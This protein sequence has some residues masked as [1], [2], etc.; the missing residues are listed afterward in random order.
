VPALLETSRKER[1]S[2]DAWLRQAQYEQL[3]TAYHLGERF[4]R[5][6]DEVFATVQMVVQILRR[7]LLNAASQSAE[8]T[9]EDAPK[10]LTARELSQA[11]AATLRCLGDLGVNARPRLTLETMVMSWP[12]MSHR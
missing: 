6:R 2:A 8:A 1:D 5:N 11:I 7:E 3:I 9:A 10:T 12:D 4:T